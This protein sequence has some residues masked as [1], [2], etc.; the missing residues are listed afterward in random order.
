MKK[1]GKM[2][3]EVLRSFLCKPA[4]HLY[5]QTKAQLPDRFRGQIKFIAAKCIGCKLCMRDCPT[6][7]ITISKVGDKR[8]QAE[9]DLDRCM[10]CAQCVDVCPKQAL[11]ASADYELA[12]LQRDKLKAVFYAEP[13][14]SAPAPLANAP[15]GQ[16]A[17]SA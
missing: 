10:Y 14:P 3:G 7:C 11:I 5:P 12:Q 6:S 1:P 15:S 8:F 4:T 17:A 9:F 2:L 13:A 16:P